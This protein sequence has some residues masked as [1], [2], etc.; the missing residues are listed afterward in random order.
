MKRPNFGKMDTLQSVHMHRAMQVALAMKL[1]A[2]V[3]QSLIT[4]D[5]RGKSSLLPSTLL[6]QFTASSYSLSH[7]RSHHGV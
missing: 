4:S 7:L 2:T 3:P 6:H 1:A 5:N